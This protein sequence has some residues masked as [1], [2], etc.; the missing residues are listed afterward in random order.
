VH[1]GLALGGGGA[2]GLAHV[3]MLEVFDELGVRPDCMAGTSMGAVIGA[4]YASGLSARDLHEN[5]HQLAVSGRLRDALPRRDGTVRWLELIRLDWER[6]GV[7]SVDRLMSH[8]G[9]RLE[10]RTFEDLKIPLKIVA[11]DFWQRDEVVLSR[12]ELIPAIQAS[13]ALPGVFRP[14][15]RAGRMLVDGGAVNPVPFD[16]LQDDCDSIVAINVVGKRRKRSDRPPNI[17]AAIFNTYQIMQM[18]IVRQKL[19]QRAPTIYIEPDLVDIRMLEFYKADEIFAQAQPAK[20][21]L[22]RLLDNLLS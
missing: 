2:R 15:Q 21:Q 13:M 16:L 22:K 7:I 1:L 20:E 8:I 14:V 17:T 5:L 18:S 11:A 10:A 4:L 12:G 9:A 6:G 19:R 3:C